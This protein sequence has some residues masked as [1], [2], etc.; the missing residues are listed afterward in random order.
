MTVR[1]GP[2]EIKPTHIFSLSDGD[3]TLGFL[4]TDRSGRISPVEGW[5]Q[6]PMPRT[7]MKLSQGAASYEDFELP[8]TSIIQQSLEGGM[9]AENFEDDRTR[10]RDGRHVDTTRGDVLCGPSVTEKILVNRPNIGDLSYFSNHTDIY[11]TH[12]EYATKII[13]DADTIVTSVDCLPTIGPIPELTHIHYIKIY[14]DSGGSPNT[15][16]AYGQRTVN[17]TDIINITL[18]TP[19]SLTDGTSYWVASYT[20]VGEPG[21]ELV[22][23]TSIRAETGGEIKYKNSGGTWAL[24][25]S[26]YSISFLM[27]GTGFAPSKAVF[28]EHRRNL[29]VV[30]NED[31]GAPMLFRNGY[32]G[33]GKDNAANLTQLKTDRDLSVDMNGDALNLA[34]KIVLIIEGPGALEETPWRTIVSN[35]ITGTND[36][37]T[38]DEPWKITH[39][40]A[41]SWVVLGSDDWFEITGHGL[42][43]KVTDV[44][45]VYDHVIIAQGDAINMRKFRWRNNAGASTNDFT[46]DGTNKADKLLMV[47]DTEGAMKLWKAM[48]TDNIVDYAPA[49]LYSSNHTFAAK[50][51]KIGTSTYSD[52]KQLIAYGDPMIPYVIKEDTFGSIQNDIY[53]EL[54]IGELKAVRSEYNGIAAMMHGVYLYFNIGERLERFYDRRLDDVGPDRGEGLPSG[55]QGIIRKLLPYPGKF[56][57]LLFT[58]NNTPSILCFNGMGWNEVWRP[59]SVTSDGSGATGDDAPF[60]YNVSNEAGGRSQDMIVQ[61]I[62]GK[63]SDRLWFDY[64]GKICYI[65]ITINPRKDNQYRYR[66]LSQY[67]TA[68]IYGNLKDVN[69]YWHSIKLHTENLTSTET[70]KRLI[71]VEYKID[72]DADW[73]AVGVANTSPIQELML[74]ETNSV[75]GYRIKF[76]LTLHTSNSALSPRLIAMVVKGVIRVDVK[77]GWVVTCTSENVRDLNGEPDNQGNLMTQLDAWANSDISPAPLKMRHNITYYDDKYV[78]IDPASLSFQQVALAPQRASAE[79]QYKELL[80]FT[81]YEV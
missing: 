3:K 70:V 19:V 31:T 72:E 45:I 7:A 69:K 24:R 1:V 15:L 61:V 38:V 55:R 12:K 20:L 53:A 76:R 13:P 9:N 44:C 74:S 30:I 56:Y 17:N 21:G 32:R 34:G 29:Y 63:A 81:I 58:E 66:D 80:K 43:G 78:F 60:A 28:F 35:T 27:W 68:W 25:S 2:D 57:T 75:T 79:R 5:S 71:K 62:P 59:T 73:T 49:Q 48:V 18:N 39:T 10:Y 54:P 36:I 26:N 50:N 46:A 42:T 47:A 23:T 77:K 33:C 64:A 8:F 67:E 6:A 4:T 51:I 52:I 37:I 16:L 14:S 41:T 40:T 11:G 22:I 65:P